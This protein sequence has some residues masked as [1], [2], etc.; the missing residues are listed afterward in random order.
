[1]QPSCPGPTSPPG[2][3]GGECLCLFCLASLFSFLKIKTITRWTPHYLLYPSLCSQLPEE[4]IDGLVNH[5]TVRLLFSVPDVISFKGLKY[6]IRI[7]CASW[8][9]KYYILLGFGGGGVVFGCGPQHGSWTR[10]LETMIWSE[11]KSR[12]PNGLSRPSAPKP[13]CFK[14]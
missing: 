7:N 5:F 1:M 4:D 14:W 10:D 12:T 9:E 8:Q 2:G 6:Q 11:T 13:L 3:Q